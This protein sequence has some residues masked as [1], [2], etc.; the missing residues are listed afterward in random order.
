MN[1]LQLSLEAR[2]KGIAKAIDHA[3]QVHESWGEKAYGMFRDFI[4][5]RKCEFMCEDFRHAV[6][7]L[8]PNPPHNRAFGNVLMRAAKAGLIERVRYAPVRNVKAHRANASVW[9]TT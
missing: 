5:K 1:Q 7:G 3:N 8:L 6:T 9:R 2:D 4:Y